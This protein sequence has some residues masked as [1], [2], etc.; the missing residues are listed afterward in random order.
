MRCAT[1]D[2]RR[3]IGLSTATSEELTAWR[4]DGD[5]T[6][7]TAQWYRCAVDVGLP[8]EGVRRTLTFDGL[9][10]VAEV[11]LDDVLVHES[12]SMFLRSSV[13][14]DDAV[15]G[16]VT[17]A[18]CCRALAP[19]LGESRKP[20]ARWRTKLAAANLRFFRT[21]LLGRTPGIAPD[22]PVIGPWRPVRFERRSVVGVASLAVAA[23]VERGA[24]H[25]TV[26]A[27]VATFGDAP[28]E[29][30]E[31]RVGGELPVSLVVS[32]GRVSGDAVIADPPLWWPHTHGD[33]ATL[34]VTIAVTVSGTVVEIDAGRVGFR[35][36]AFDDAQ[37]T[38]GGV[39]VFVRGAV[40]TPSPDDQLEARLGLVR[41][42]GLNMLRVVGTGAYEQPRFYDLCDQLGIVVW[43]DFMF[44]NF[45]YPIA[46]DGVR[47][48]VEKEA[49]QVTGE[50]AHRPSV[51]VFCGG[52]EIEQQVAMLGLDP[53]LAQGPLSTE[54]LPGAVA[55]SG[56]DAAYVT[57]SPSGG[58]LPFRFGSGVAHYFGVGGYRRPL[59]D[60]RLAGVRFASECLAFANVPDDDAD[61]DR[62]VPADAGAD[63]TFADVRDHYLAEHYGVDPAGLRRDDLARYLALSRQISGELIAAVFGEWRRP[64]SP[65]GGGLVLWLADLEPGSGWGLLDD[66]GQPKVAY[67]H[68]RRASAP[69]AV[70][71]TDEGLAGVAVH[72]ANDHPAALETTLRVA[73]YEDAGHEVAAAELPVAI[74]PHSAVSFDAEQLIG[75]FVD[76][77]WAYRFGPAAHTSVVA[78]LDLP[79]IAPAVLFPAGPPLERADP[80]RLGLRAEH[81]LAGGRAV[82]RLS[83]ER[84]V[85]GVRLAVPG[86]VPED[87]AFTLEP[88]RERLVRLTS[89]E[90][91]GTPTGGTVTALNLDRPVTL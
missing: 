77:S 22:A 39:P 87:D 72:V 9:A 35:T 89:N 48:L 8:A 59:S 2:G 70:W 10:T 45:D 64:D 36:M 90:A 63:W 41:D 54:L 71:L 27:L 16:E 6:D 81:A 78:S 46:D 55:A 30:A 60:V 37:L 49:A 14:L 44:A 62:G 65:C 32:G 75:R 38:V 23:R 73:L 5:G 83:C 47:V 21:Q 69:V 19:L 86:F 24:G 12:R 34:P 68:L 17:V 1:D 40:W 51:A 13:D 42:A 18:I 26:D 56:S 58:A 57:S 88:G 29:A 28:V 20:R 50:L 61:W 52:S 74:E 3:L 53:E 33:P 79:D 85:W 15:R 25:V 67:H 76:A 11:Y 66:R 43:Q 4:H 7:A 91:S 80:E 31:L 82:V 84:L